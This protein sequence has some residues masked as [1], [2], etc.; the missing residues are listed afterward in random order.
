MILN[1]CKVYYINLE[2]D[3]ERK[4]KVEIELKKV[5]REEQINRFNGI[6]H[7]IPFYG[8][9]ISHI[10]VLKDALNSKEDNIFIFEDDVVWTYDMPKTKNIINSIKDY[11]IVMLYYNI[12]FGETILNFKKYEGNQNLYYIINGRA[13]AGYLIK[14]SFIPKLLDIWENTLPKILENPYDRENTIDR[15]WNVLEKDNKFLAIIPRLLKIRG[16]YSN[17]GKKFLSPGGFCILAIKNFDN[18]QNNINNECCQHELFNN[19]E[20]DDYI[21][22]YIVEKYEHVDNIFFINNYKKIDPIKFYKIYGYICHLKIDYAFDLNCKDI[23]IISKN[24]INDIS[25]TEK[26]FNL[27]NIF[28]Q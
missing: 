14:K 12:G 4:E 25:K 19:N 3:T 5:F 17:I 6:Y 15:T 24:Y 2:K 11:D 21:K 22:K 16:C 9:G 27:K 8:C 10:N 18:N 23:Y 13:C 7:D 1:N 26:A 28:Y 20:S